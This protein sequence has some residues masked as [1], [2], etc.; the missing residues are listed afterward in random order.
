MTR[1]S[2]DG[3]KML[4][5]QVSLCNKICSKPHIAY[6]VH[7]HI[8]NKKEIKCYFNSDAPRKVGEKVVARREGKKKGRGRRE[9]K[10]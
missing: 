4:R 6:M 9:E 8:S 7:Y 2:G 10:N 1:K 3:G 5:E